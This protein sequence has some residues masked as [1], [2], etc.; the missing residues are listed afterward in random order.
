MS[1]CPCLL[2]IISCPSLIHLIRVL[3]LS[4]Q[5]TL[6]LSTLFLVLL[7]AT[8]ACLLFRG[9]DPGVILRDHHFPCRIQRRSFLVPPGPLDRHVRWRQRTRGTA[10][11]VFRIQVVMVVRHS[12]SV[13]SITIIT[14][15]II[16]IVR[17]QLSVRGIDDR[18]NVLRRMILW[19]M[20][21][22]RGWPVQGTLQLQVVRSLG[23][24]VTL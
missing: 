18:G 3:S 14:R 11:R 13:V 2:L 15:M 16:I 22:S 17:L 6:L 20:R 8:C 21:F 12:S 7:R 23:R 9:S 10:I 4:I 5:I 24:R 19:Q 1:F